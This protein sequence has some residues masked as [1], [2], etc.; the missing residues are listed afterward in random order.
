MIAHGPIFLMTSATISPVRTKAVALTVIAEVE[1][2]I[3]ATVVGSHS[4]LPA[5]IVQVIDGALFV[6]DTVG[7]AV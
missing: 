4:V 2:D 1:P 5:I 3:L 6:L 7:L